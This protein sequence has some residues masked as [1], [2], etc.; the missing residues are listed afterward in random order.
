MAAGV[1]TFRAG[2]MRSK[3]PPIP[4]VPGRQL[5][6]DAKRGPQGSPPRIPLASEPRVEARWHRI[7]N[8]RKGRITP[9]DREAHMRANPQDLRTALKAVKRTAEKEI[10]R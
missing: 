2:S 9:R 10:A 3:A 8:W 6:A 5:Q 7:E 4:R 1:N